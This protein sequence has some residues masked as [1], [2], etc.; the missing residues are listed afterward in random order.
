[1]MSQA[2]KSDLLVVSGLE[3]GFGDVG[4]ASISLQGNSISNGLGV[5]QEDVDETVG[6]RPPGLKTS[7]DTLLRREKKLP[8]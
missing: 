3:L 5:S 2:Y 4:E 8:T 7:C 1:M 6:T